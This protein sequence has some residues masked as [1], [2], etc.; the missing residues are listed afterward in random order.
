MDTQAPPKPEIVS[1]PNDPSNASTAH[2]EFRAG[3][4][5]GQP[6]GRVTLVRSMF[7][8]LKASDAAGTAESFQCSVDGAE[9]APCDSPRSVPVDAG[10]HEFR[11]RAADAAGNHSDA[12]AFSW[13]VDLQPP[14]TTI[15]KGP[16]DPSDVA[17]A[18][19]EFTSNEPGS[20]FECRLG[21][22][23]FSACSSPKAFPPLGEGD[24]RF[25]VRATGNTDP[26]PASRNWT[27]QL[28]NTT[29]VV[30][31]LAWKTGP[32]DLDL[33]VQT[34][35]F[36]ADDGGEV[37]AGN[38]CHPDC[39]AP[40]AELNHDSA[41]APGQETITVS[42]QGS[43]EFFD[44]AY[45]VWVE[46]F[47]CDATFDG[48]GATISVT[49]GGSSL[50]SFTVASAGGDPSLGTWVVGG[51]HIT[52]EGSA[53][54]SGPGTLDGDS[55]GAVGLARRAVHDAAPEIL[56]PDPSPSPQAGG[57][58]SAAPSPS[59]G[60]SSGGTD[61]GTPTPAP[62]PTESSPT[63]EPSPTQTTPSPE[64]SPTE[65]TPEPTPPATTTPPS[66]AAANPAAP[67]A[68]P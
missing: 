1:G 20:T 23:P 48:S 44:G 33:H 29:P 25:Q 68:T 9:F 51:V 42:P 10:T 18:T 63:P 7:A 47:S 45:H 57:G 62:S 35:D 6:Q 64:P 67:E 26:T 12:A 60:P 40:W 36:T 38:P 21:N 22:G 39:G 52:S 28:G 46:N 14:Q 17:D 50:G 19:F 65:T 16:Q 53:S 34:P 43:G 5:A 30:I 58:P 56:G 61:G 54:A 59:A 24:H 41:S 32:S 11:V 66:A 4:G 15:T 37:W 2:F 49:Q 8:G 55:C 13:K 31:K 27:I 3:G